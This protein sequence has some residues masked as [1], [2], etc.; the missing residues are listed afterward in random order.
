MDPRSKK[1]AEILGLTNVISGQLDVTTNK[2]VGWDATMTLSYNRTIK[3]NSLNFLAGVNATS[4]T[5]DGL[6]ISYRG[7]PSGSLSSPG[8]AHSIYGNPSASD[9]MK[10]FRRL[11]LYTHA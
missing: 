4:S 10:K 9:A 3:K 11:F 2:S 7:F 5:G 1:N 6:A 8:Y